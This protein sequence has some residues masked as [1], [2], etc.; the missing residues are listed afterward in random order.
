MAP[1]TLVGL[2]ALSVEIITT[3][4]APKARAASATLRLPTTLVSTPSIGLASTIG[5]CFSAAA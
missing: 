4:E 2:T 1:I 5:R 3:S